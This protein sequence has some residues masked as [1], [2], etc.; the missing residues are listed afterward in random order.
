MNM[1]SFIL[2]LAVS[3]NAVAVFDSSSNLQHVF[4]AIHSS[5][6]QWGSSLNHN[7]MSF[8]LAAVPQG[9]LLHHGTSHGNRVHGMEWLAFEPEHALNFAWA[10]CED[11]KSISIDMNQLSPK[12]WLD[13]EHHLNSESDVVAQAILK[14]D[15]KPP[16]PP[17]QPCLKPGWLHTYTTSRNLHLLYL[18]GQSAAKSTMGTLDA[19]D[20]ILARNASLDGRAF[21]DWTRA[22]ALCETAATDY[23]HKIDG[24]LRMEHGFEIILCDFADV[25]VVNILPAD[26]TRE[27][28]DSMPDWSEVFEFFETVTSRYH[29]IGARRAILNYDNF[30]SAYTH[31]DAH[32][33]SENDDL[34]RLNNISNTT[35][36]QIS[37][38]IKSLVLSGDF[39]SS[40]HTTIDWQAIIDAYIARS[41]RRLERFM[42]SEITNSTRLS[43]EIELILRPYL[44]RTELADPHTVQRCANA[45][46]PTS[47]TSIPLSDHTLAHNATLA[48]STAICSV[49]HTAMQTTSFSE[50]RRM[51]SDLIDVLNWT[52]WKECQSS[53]RVNEICFTAIWPFGSQIDHAIPNCKNAQEIGDS[54]GYWRMGQ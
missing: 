13:W 53:C 43:F 22:E 3:C 47:L 2:F 9:V 25:D 26:K 44:N 36:S 31:T 52:T 27:N 45:Y 50:Q 37:E 17:H 8:F 5:M 46:I 20:Y 42:S 10:R 14:Q 54:W 41:S 34:P 21:G 51:L 29:G 4:N 19:Q 39:P 15:D 28:I 18:D 40:T 35:A 33:F 32:L 11:D 38:E 16:P 12:W 1:L 24:Y 49:L 7:G 6:R 23:D 30:V 48:V